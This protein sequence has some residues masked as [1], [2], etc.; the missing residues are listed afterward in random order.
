MK[1]AYEL[2]LERLESQGIERPREDSLSEAERQR[3]AALGGKTEGLA[4]EITRL[5]GELVKAAAVPWKVPVTVAGNSTRAMR[6]IS[7]VA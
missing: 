1:S 6:S 2:A 7:L 3:L 5:Q 4:A